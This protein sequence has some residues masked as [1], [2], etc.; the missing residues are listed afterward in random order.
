MVGVFLLMALGVAVLVFSIVAAIKSADGEY[1]R[2]PLTIRFI[3]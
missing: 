3:Q 2:Y 1:Y